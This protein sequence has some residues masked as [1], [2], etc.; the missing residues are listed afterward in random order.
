MCVCILI[1]ICVCDYM[2]A[3]IRVCV[4]IPNLNILKILEFHSIYIP[5]Y[6]LITCILF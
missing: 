3:C 1:Y 4:C 2:Y 5:C 6:F